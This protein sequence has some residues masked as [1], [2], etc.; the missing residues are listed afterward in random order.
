MTA[1]CTAGAGC[2]PRWR[3]G[4][5][6]SS[7]SSARP[8]PIRDAAALYAALDA[9]RLARM[10]DNAAALVAAGRLRDGVS[11][12][13]ARDVLWLTTSPERYDLLVDQRG[14][15]PEEFSRFVT[16]LMAG[17]LLPPPSLSRGR[18]G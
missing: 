15:T 17:A 16:D 3:P 11:Q 8:G 10:E 12:E 2:S 14:W 4:S 9:A 6:P 5:L 13:R 7:S 18:G 1:R